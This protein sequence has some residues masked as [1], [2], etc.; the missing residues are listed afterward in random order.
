MEKTKFKNTLKNTLWDTYQ[1]KKS[2]ENIIVKERIL[3]GVT[4]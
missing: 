4:A 1:L 2:G 3:T